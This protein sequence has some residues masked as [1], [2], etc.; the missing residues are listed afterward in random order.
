MMKE[1]WGLLLNY[2]FL[3]CVPCWRFM[4]LSWFFV[5][6][7]YVIKLCQQKPK[8]E[9]DLSREL[10]C[11]S[12]SFGRLILFLSSN[13]YPIRISCFLFF[14]AFAFNDIRLM[15]KIKDDVERWKQ[16]NKESDK[17]CYRWMKRRRAEER[18]H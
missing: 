2:D 9:L 3:L 14:A 11:S 15:W 1:T 10:R 17:L 8:Q 6:Y 12:S 5:G 4:S 18:I 13:F 16:G 7:N